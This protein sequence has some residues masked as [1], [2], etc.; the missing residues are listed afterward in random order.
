MLVI[1][2]VDDIRVILEQCTTK[3]LNCDYKIFILD[4]NHMLTVQA[5][6][7]LLKIL[8]EPPEFVIFIFCTTNPEKVLPTILSRVQRFN[9]SR[10][11]VQGIKNRLKY[12]IEQ[13]NKESME[14]TGNIKISY[15]ES[16]IEYI[17]KLAKGGMR[18]SITTL[19]MCLDFSNNLTLD[20]VLK[21]TSGGVNEDVLLNF[22]AYTL[23][24]QC[25]EALEYFNEIYM[26]GVST[27]LFVQ[28]YVDFLENCIKYMIT[29]SPTIVTISDNVINRLENSMQ[30]LPNIRAQLQDILTVRTGYGSEDLKVLIESWIIKICN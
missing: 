28:L 1:I 8:E 12:I 5:S 29:K 30:F 16:A 15:E 26:S 18:D 2:G 7:A 22:M 23:N 27:S 10:I 14:Q 3:P 25:K 9:F 6:N 21:V 11:S 24:K 20:N 13:E 4:E 19:E 17:A